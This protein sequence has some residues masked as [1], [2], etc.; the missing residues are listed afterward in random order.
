MDTAVCYS[1][2]ISYHHMSSGWRSWSWYLIRMSYDNVIMSPGWHTLP[3]L[4]H[5]DEI[6]NF[7]FSQH[8]VALQ[9]FHEIQFNRQFTYC[10]SCWLSTHMLT[11]V[12]RSFTCHWPRL[13]WPGPA[14]TWRNDKVIIMSKRRLISS[15]HVRWAPIL[16][17]LSWIQWRDLWYNT[18]Q[19]QLV[20]FKGQR[21]I[22][23]IDMQENTPY[24]ESNLVACKHMP[25]CARTRVGVNSIIS[26]Q[27]QLQLQ[28]FQ[29][30]LQLQPISRISTPTPTP[31]PG[32]ATPTPIQLRQ[33]SRISTQTQTQTPEVST[34]TPIPT[35]ANL[36]NINS[37]SNSNSGDFNSNSNSNSGVSNPTP[38]P[39]QIQSILFN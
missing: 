36:Q 31:T 23:K 35:P 21:A 19:R 16:I 9:R 18:L 30:Q 27:L 15:P 24:R 13:N 14:G 12:A 28:R 5:P 32:V 17:Q 1:D 11:L 7:D 3:F 34:Q 4:S 20:P 8:A 37:N 22:A 6:A 2:D 39:F 10:A 29:L 38:T 33:I 25:Q 26:T